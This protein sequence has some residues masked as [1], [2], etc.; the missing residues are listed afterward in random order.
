MT[1]Q[2]QAADANMDATNLYREDVIT[3]RK[4]GT[5]RRLTPITPEG[6]VDNAR[7]VRYIGQAQ[8]MTAAG[9]FPLSFDIDASTL[10]EAVKNYGEAAKAGYERAVQELQEMRRQAASSIVVPGSGAAP[11]GAGKIQ[12]P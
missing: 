7:P 2:Q 3:D 12:M 6:E 9:P 1:D 5:I 10:A 11:G 8:L 4:V